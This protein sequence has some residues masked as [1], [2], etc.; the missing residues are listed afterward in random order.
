MT[1]DFLEIIPFS[2][3]S[4]YELEVPGSKSISNRALILAV[5]N[6]EEVEL[7][8][9]LDSQDV[10][11]M[12]TALTSLGVELSHD[13]ESKM[14]KIRGC[15]GILPVKKAKIN[16]GN[17]GTVARF[18]TA[19]LS[20]QKGGQYSLDGSPA[21][22]KRPMQGL[23]N[24]LKLHGAEFNFTIEKNC[25]PFT[26]KTNSLS[27][28]P[29]EIDASESSQILSAILLIAPLISGLTEIN[30]IGHTVSQPFVKMTLEMIQQ[31]MPD[32][33][34]DCSQEDNFKLPCRRY[35]LKGKV[36]KIEPDATAAS[37]FLSSPLALGGRVTVKNLQQCRLQGDIEYCDVIRKCGVS[38]SNSDIGI[39][40]MI[41]THPIGGDFDFNDISDTFL[42][43]A[44]LSPL[45]QSPLTISGIAHTRKQETDRLGA[46]ANELRKMG[47]KV[48]ETI[49]TI[50]IIP[51]L[52]KLF[53][54][55]PFTIET[56]E[57]H[58]FAMSFAILGSHDL[59]K[60]GKSWLRILNANCC[61]KTFP[62]FFSLLGDFRV[63]C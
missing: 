6:D 34:V 12:I 14:I 50:S 18:I 43:L 60:N 49:D 21:M 57:D 47:Q 27:V 31:F 58:R 56:Y 8:G 13:I 38:I 11:I 7:H 45:L 26:I 41:K 29:W 19:L 23:L 10:N 51:D 44:A 37:Y 39:H 33:I 28:D 61:A 3:K 35:S 4:N 30:L 25:F 16:V 54:L 62:D 15:G 1:T 2:N 52:N 32:D 5:L 40:S 22:R 53:N 55:A 59:F 36:Y 24:A 42:T 48:D 9:I 63:S 17:A 20:L 46:M